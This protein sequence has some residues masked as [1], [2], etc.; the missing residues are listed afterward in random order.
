MLDIDASFKPK[1]I[2][3]KHSEKKFIH[4]MYSANLSNTTL[5]IFIGILCVALFQCKNEQVKTPTIAPAPAQNTTISE[6]NFDSLAQDSTHNGVVLFNKGVP[7]DLLQK[8]IQTMQNGQ[9]AIP[10][11]WSNLTDVSYAVKYSQQLK[12]SINF[13]EFGKPVKKWNEQKVTI[14][15]YLIPLDMGHYALSKNPY[16][17]CF[18]CGGAGPETIIGL[19]FTAPPPRYKTDEFKT[20]SGVFRLND[21]DVESFMYQLSAVQVK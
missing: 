20:I 14:S 3:R 17:S 19:T 4:K 1:R 15:G 9:S 10:L 18:F 2:Y 8:D 7:A 5:S 11:Q 16:A 21:T 6:L 12:D 13:P